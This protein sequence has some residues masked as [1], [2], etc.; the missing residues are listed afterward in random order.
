MPD[1]KTTNKHF[2]IFKKYHQYYIN[3]YHLGGWKIYYVH[4]DTNGNFADTN[5][6]NLESRITKIRFGKYWDT[7]RPLNNNEL[8]KLAKHE[9]HTYYLYE[10]AI[11][12]TC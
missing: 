4:V 5:C 1:I 2:E 7:Q 9:A 6:N 8:R 3:K 12:G 10:I 11:Y